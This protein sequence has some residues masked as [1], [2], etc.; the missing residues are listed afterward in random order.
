MTEMQPTSPR[1]PLIVTAPPRPHDVS[2]LTPE[3]VLEFKRIL[4]D[5]PKAHGFQ[6]PR[7]TL[8]GLQLLLD[9]DFGVDYSPGA[10]FSMVRRWD[11]LDVLNLEMEPDPPTRLSP[12][13]QERARR[14]KAHH[15]PPR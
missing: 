15:Q 13:A 3:Q 1:G 14:L 2:R 4:K 9:E 10:I 6:T 8:R 7:W 12:A 5:E 11:M